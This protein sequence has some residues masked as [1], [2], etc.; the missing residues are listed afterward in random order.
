MEQFPSKSTG[1][2][3]WPAA[4]CLCKYLLHLYEIEKQFFEKKRVLELGSGLGLCGLF[5]AAFGSEKVILTDRSLEVLELLERNVKKN[6]TE[7]NNK[8][9]WKCLNGVLVWK[10]SKT[11]MVVLI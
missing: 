2:I 4:L 3:V 8:S 1:L 11:R 10:N 7:L 6:F 5:A 9:F